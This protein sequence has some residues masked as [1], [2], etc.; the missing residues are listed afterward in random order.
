MKKGPTHFTQMDVT[1]SHQ[2][3]KTQAING[4][5]NRFFMCVLNHFTHTR[6]NEDVGETLLL[7]TLS[8][9]YNGIQ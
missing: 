7:F 9:K 8:L 3:L 4:A 2:K 6:Q 5:L 1:Y